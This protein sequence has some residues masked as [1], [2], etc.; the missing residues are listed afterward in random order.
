[1]ISWEA[2]R[3]ALNLDVNKKIYWR[4]IIHAI[5]RACKEMLLECGNNISNL[6][7]NEHHLI[8]KPQIYCLK[9]LNSR[10]LYNMQLIL[11]VEKTTA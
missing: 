2:L 10:Q 5:L 11:N 3:A 8:K 4:Q 7:I 6:I 9:K 1:M